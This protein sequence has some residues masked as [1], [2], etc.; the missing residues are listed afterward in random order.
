MTTSLRGLEVSVV[1]A[2]K[3]GRT[4]GRLLRRAGASIA[5]VRCRRLSHAR[6][7]VR[8]I[9]A[10]RPQADVS[11]GLVIVAVPDDALK[12]VIA[13]LPGIRVHCSGGLDAASVGA[14][15]AFHP[16][17]SFADPASAAASFAGTPVAVE[18]RVAPLLERVAR[19]IGGVPFR[20]RPGRKAAYH[21][22]AV[23]ASNYVVAAV[24]AA[25]RLFE[26]AGVPRS[27]GLPALL[28]LTRGTVANLDR[29][30]LPDALTGPIE[31]GDVET[32]RRHLRAA[33]KLAPLYA[34]LGRL[35]VEVARAKGTLSAARAKRIDALLRKR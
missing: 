18:G 4:L 28:G 29:V 33:G 31:R 12:G 35:T 8:F 23:F 9:G 24:E 22:G 13:G 5:A 15:G 14:D 6:E 17:R 7:A 34:A 27:K 10:G 3:V 26:E 25:V 30:G 20:I 2:G 21:A 11:G 16:L 1:G 32:L 19:A